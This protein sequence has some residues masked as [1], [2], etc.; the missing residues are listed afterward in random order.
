MCKQVKEPFTQNNVTNLHLRL[1]DSN[2][3]TIDDFLRHKQGRL[4]LR[5]ESVSTVLKWIILLLP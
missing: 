1:I 3:K 5:T 2:S 4:F